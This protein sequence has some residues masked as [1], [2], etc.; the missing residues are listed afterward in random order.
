MSPLRSKSSV[1]KDLPVSSD[2]YSS[3]KERKETILE[4]ESE[5]SPTMKPEF[6][7]KRTH[8]ADARKAVAEFEEKTESKT[9]SLATDSDY[10][11]VKS[12]ELDSEGNAS[13][14]LKSS[15]VKEPK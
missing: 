14:M 5:H 11:S 3:S 13:P 9:E 2:E 4:V 12:D 7:V 10:E 8:Y 6:K 15:K 1:P